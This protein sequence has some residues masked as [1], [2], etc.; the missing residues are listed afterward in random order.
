MPAS[1]SELLDKIIEQVLETNVKIF[2][3]DNLP[4][5]MYSSALSTYKLTKTQ[6]CN[7]NVVGLYQD[8]SINHCSI[9]DFYDE[10]CN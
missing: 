4:K 5:E 6:V 1:K 10:S 3:L 2:S 8:I 9:A 7:V